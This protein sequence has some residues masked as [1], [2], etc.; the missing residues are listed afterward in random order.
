M[1]GKIRLSNQIARRIYIFEN[2]RFQKGEMSNETEFSKNL[3]SLW[4]YLY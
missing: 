2:I 4:R 3:A 1:C